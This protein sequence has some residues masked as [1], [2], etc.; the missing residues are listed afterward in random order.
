MNEEHSDG[1]YEAP[2]AE[3]LDASGRPGETSAGIS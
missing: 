1:T 2:K 3:E